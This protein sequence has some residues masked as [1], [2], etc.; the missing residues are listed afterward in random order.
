MTGH[1]VTGVQ[2]ICRNRRNKRERK[3]A[4]RR[5]RLLQGL[6]SLG[7]VLFTLLLFGG[8]YALY[9]FY[10]SIF[11]P[12]SPSTPESFPPPTP[13]VNS[14]FSAGSLKPVP[15]SHHSTYSSTLPDK[16]QLFKAKAAALWQDHW[17]IIVAVLAAVVVLVFL[18]VG[19]LVYL[20]SNDLGSEILAD[21][22]EQK[23]QLELERE[24]EERENLKW[25]VITVLLGLY[26]ASLVLTIVMIVLGFLVGWDNVCLES[27][28]VRIVVLLV[29]LLFLQPFF[30]LLC[31]LLL[32]IVNAVE[33]F[34]VR[35][36][37]VLFA[38]VPI[39]LLL[40]FWLCMLMSKSFRDLIFS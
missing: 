15:L 8:A 32:Y 7:L 33:Y 31:F 37:L 26:S 17:K 27:L 18:G 9:M 13:I 16:L 19:L 39:I 21:E 4:N 10:D 2:N 38:I 24:E 35:I 28:P 36:I 23:R 34:V 6:L 5:V 11:P 30:L 40:P 14:V 25:T 29:S 22:E 12:S 20:N 3:K 1:A